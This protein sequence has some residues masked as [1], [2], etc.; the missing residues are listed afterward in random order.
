MPPRNANQ[1][2]THCSWSSMPTWFGPELAWPTSAT[3][4]GEARLRFWRVPHSPH[5]QGRRHLAVHDTTHSRRHEVIADGLS[6]EKGAVRVHS[7]D[8]WPKKKPPKV[9]FFLWPLAQEEAKPF[10]LTREQVRL[11]VPFFSSDFRASRSL[12]GGTFFFF[13]FL[14]LVFFW[15]E[16][17]FL[18]LFLFL[19]SFSFSFSFL[20]FFL[21]LFFF[22]K[23]FLL[24][25]IFLFWERRGCV[26]CVWGMSRE[27]EERGEGEGEGGRGGEGEKKPTLGCPSF[28]LTSGCEEP[29]LGVR[30]RSPFSDFGARRSPPGGTLFFFSCSCSCSFSFAVAVAFACVC[31]CFFFFL[32]FSFSSSFFDCSFFRFFLIFFCFF[33]RL[34]GGGGSLGCPSSLLTSGRQEAYLGYP[35]S[36]LTSGRDSCSCSCSCSLSLSLSLSFA[37]AVALAFSFSF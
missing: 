22:E 37:V 27:E 11:E 13:S 2:L 14:V 36:L 21:F 10:L 23:C 24:F 4:V 8:L 16:G 33:F 18:F 5:P 31:S 32:C 25:W 35:S 26:V 17:G 19:F 29:N 9:P 12:P 15:G 3:A 7:R 28:V 20:F 6:L 1:L 34:L 30:R